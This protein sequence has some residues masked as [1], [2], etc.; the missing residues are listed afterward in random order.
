LPGYIAAF[1]FRFFLWKGSVLIR[2]HPRPNRFFVV[3]SLAGKIC[4]YLCSSVSNKVFGC[5][6]ASL[7]SSVSNK[8]FWLRSGHAVHYSVSP[9]PS[10]FFF[11][12][13]GRFGRISRTMAVTMRM[14]EMG[15]VKK[16]EKLP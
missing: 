1:P 4:V 10:H 5:G 15:R 7:S 12:I 6:P 8:T 2:V 16:M 13:Q 14:A 9:N 11:L 3:R